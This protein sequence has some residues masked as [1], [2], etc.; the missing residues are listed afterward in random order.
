MKTIQI[1]INIV[2]ALNSFTMIIPNL[3]LEILN[4]KNY[5]FKIQ[6]LIYENQKMLIK[7]RQLYHRKI[8]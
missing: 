1:L 8:G 7:F 3:N 2:V 6:W 5:I 4:N